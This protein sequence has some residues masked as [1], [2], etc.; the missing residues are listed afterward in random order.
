MPRTDKPYVTSRSSPIAELRVRA[1]LL[2][3]AA[4]AK[5]GIS[6]TGLGNVERGVRASDALLERMAEL[7]GVAPATVVR[8]YRAGRRGFIA[9]ERP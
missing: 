8:A 6:D 4:A 7:Y 9:R 1:G 5:L 2:R 3:A